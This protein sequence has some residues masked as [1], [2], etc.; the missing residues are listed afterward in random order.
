MGIVVIIL[1]ALTAI[2][3]I[4][5]IIRT[6]KNRRLKKTFKYADLICGYWEPVEG[7]EC[8]LE[9]NKYQTLIRE[10]K[11][12]EEWWKQRCGYSLSD[13]TLIIIDTVSYRCLIRIFE[14][15]GVTYLEIFG[16]QDYAGKYRKK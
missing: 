4:I 5:Y 8:R 1:A 13:N 9:F 10:Y 11:V 2:V 6:R 7:T 15:N 3:S 14:E 12:E 16:H